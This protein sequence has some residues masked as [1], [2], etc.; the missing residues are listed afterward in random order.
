MEQC[1]LLGFPI[2]K[3]RE[4]REFNVPKNGKENIP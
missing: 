3:E 1:S 4:E 2:G